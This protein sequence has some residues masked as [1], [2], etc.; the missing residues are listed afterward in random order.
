MQDVIVSSHVIKTKSSIKK[1]REQHQA[2]EDENSDMFQE[3]YLRENSKGVTFTVLQ[4]NTR[5]L[6]SS[7]K[8]D[9]MFSEVQGCKWDVI[10]VLEK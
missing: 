3:M 10:L 5:S 8:T 4:K 9:E 7:E 2:E 6:G 1:I